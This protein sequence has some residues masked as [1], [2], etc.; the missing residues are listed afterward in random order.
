M[1][2]TITFT[3]SALTHQLKQNSLTLIK[4]FLGLQFKALSLRTPKIWSRDQSINTH[5]NIGHVACAWGSQLKPR[6]RCP[7]RISNIT[8]LCGSSDF[9][10]KGLKVIKNL[11][12]KEIFVWFQVSDKKHEKAN[13]ILVIPHNYTN[14]SIFNHFH[15]EH[16][17]LSLELNCYC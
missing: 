1:R 7:V 3:A 14:L 17:Y 11:K 16:I 2:R 9:T 8:M 6:L 15:K 4:R 5:L 13:S 12:Q 10:G